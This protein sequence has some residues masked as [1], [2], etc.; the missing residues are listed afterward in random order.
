MALD[1]TLNE[2]AKQLSHYI[3]HPDRWRDTDDDTAIKA[4]LVAVRRELIRL[5]SKVIQQGV[6][7]FTLSAEQ[8]QQRLESFERE[9]D[10]EAADEHRQLAA[11]CRN[12]RFMMN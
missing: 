2:C 10:Q 12:P 5:E 9:M 6:G 8:E 7:G 3:N 11:D 4:A 1:D